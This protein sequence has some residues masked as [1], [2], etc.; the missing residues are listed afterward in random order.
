MGFGIS[1][2]VIKIENQKELPTLRNP[3]KPNARYDYYQNGN[4][5]S[6]RFTDP[7]GVPTKSIHYTNHGNPKMHPQ[8]PH[9]HDWG[10]LNGQWTEFSEWY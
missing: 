9:T 3:G 1:G 7:N 5:K 10:W 4:L 8:V 2:G 6:S